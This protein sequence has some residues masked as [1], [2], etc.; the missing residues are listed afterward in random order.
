LGTD[1]VSVANYEADMP[2]FPIKYRHEAPRGLRPDADVVIYWRATPEAADPLWH[3][4]F[5]Q[6]DL[7]IYRRRQGL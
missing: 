2:H 6:G 1:N 7:R 3:L 5:A 4:I